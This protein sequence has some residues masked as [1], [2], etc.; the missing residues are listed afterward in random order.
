MAWGCVHYGCGR[1]PL[2]LHHAERVGLGTAG[3]HPQTGIAADTGNK[4]EVPLGAWIGAFV[5]S[6]VTL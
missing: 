3:S 6:A 4:P 1:L 2:G 5:F